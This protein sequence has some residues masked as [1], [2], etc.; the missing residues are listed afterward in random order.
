MEKPN[1]SA[2]GNGFGSSSGPQSSSIDPYDD[3]SAEFHDVLGMLYF[4]IEVFRN[5][6]TFGDDLSKSISSV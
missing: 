3:R 5:D 4:V 1:S 2:S 6:E